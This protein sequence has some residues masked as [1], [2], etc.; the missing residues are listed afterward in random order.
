MLNGMPDFIALARSFGVDGVKIT[1]R[2][3]LHRD[4]PAALH[5]QRR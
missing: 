1:E 2:E 5:H 3:A 4:L